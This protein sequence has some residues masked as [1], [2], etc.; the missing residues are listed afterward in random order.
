M[1]ALTW[2][3]LG[4]AFQEGIKT[5]RLAY[6][7]ASTALEANVDR[8]K[9][10]AI[11]YQNAVEEGQPP[12]EERDEDGYLISSQDQVYEME[13]EAAEEAL[14][15]LRK[16][17]VVALYHHW[18]RGARAWTH[19]D[20]WKDKHTQLLK[21]VQALGVQIDPGLAVVHMIAN[22]LKHDND[23]WGN[24]VRAA[25][26]DLIDSIQITLPNRT[27][28]YYAVVIPDA[29]LLQFFDAVAA[30]GPGVHTKFLPSPAPSP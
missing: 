26:S 16:A 9:E 23:D 2:N 10:D 30:S 27:E 12:I 21:K 4:L 19:A 20:Q 15:S 11:G 8:V 3:M 29:T 5:L 18:E 1:V 13:Y 17:F 22:L 6:V 28:W 14:R 25:R 7:Q 24:R